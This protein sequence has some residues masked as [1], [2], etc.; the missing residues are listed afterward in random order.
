MDPRYAPGGTVL[1]IAVANESQG[2]QDRNGNVFLVT[3]LFLRPY[4][5]SA[6]SC[7]A[8]LR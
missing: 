7:H 6:A 4:T 2:Q 1:L 3:A 8:A 5:V